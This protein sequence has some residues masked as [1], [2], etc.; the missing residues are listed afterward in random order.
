LVA[1]L[2]QIN[3]SRGIII[4]TGFIFIFLFTASC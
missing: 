3:K 4:L 1:Q 2:N